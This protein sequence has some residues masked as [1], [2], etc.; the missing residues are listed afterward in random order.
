[1]VPITWYVLHLKKVTLYGT[2][3]KVHTIM[4][5]LTKKQV[6]LNSVIM[7]VKLFS[8]EL[9]DQDM[10]DIGSHSKVYLWFDYK[11]GI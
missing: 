3:Q 2:S 5:V 4:Q 7:R 6:Q 9:S 8:S 10:T 1:M 11:F